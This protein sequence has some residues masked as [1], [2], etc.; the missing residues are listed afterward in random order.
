[1]SQT[2]TLHLLHTNDIHSRFEKMA[3]VASCLLEKRQLWESRGEYVLTVDIGDHTDRMR[4]K[5]EATWGQANIKVL[6]QSGYQYVTIGNNE[7]ITFP[8][9]VLDRLYDQAEF[10]VILS[11]LLDHE[12]NQLPKW[13]VP[14]AIHTCNDLRVALLGVTVPFA[15]FYEQ[16]GWVAKDPIPILREQVNQLRSQVDVIVVLS[17]LGYPADKKVAEQIE[18]ID[19]IL[20][21]HTHR[22]LLEGERVNQTWIAQVGMLG[23]YVGHV[24]LTIGKDQQGCKLTGFVE[25]FPT[26]EFAPDPR[27]AQLIEAEQAAADQI[28][29]EVVTELPQ[30]LAIDWEQET[31]FGSFLAASIR[32]WTQAEVG[33]ANGGLLLHSLSQGKITR[34]DLLECLPH[35]INP[36]VVQI[37]GQELWQVLEMS[38]QPDIIHKEIRGFGFRGKM[39]GW[40]GID[41]VQ[42]Y[43]QDSNHP[44]IER[45]EVGTEELDLARMYRIGTV[46]MYVFNRMFPQISDSHEHSF[47]LPEVLR[48]VL[49][50][51]ISNHERI[52]LSETRRWIRV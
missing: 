19:V 39:M 27:V 41:N 14:Y 45:I 44:V 26:S 52:R 46:D 11:N 22:L 38:L 49:A 20:G 34:K 33:L 16:L 8:K 47:F 32:Q 48:E 37:S 35:P 42:V 13:A 5:T 23:E 36:C 15:S 43:Y 31:A 18:G 21:A 6:N 7:G 10:T 4:M 3:Q 2:C 50:Q 9:E 12:Q 25:A 51:T 1:M 24:S 29:S 40:M 28:L 30:D 17:H